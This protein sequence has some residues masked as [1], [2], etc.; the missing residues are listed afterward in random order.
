MATIEAVMAATAVGDVA[1]S[2]RVGKQLRDT[3]VLTALDLAQIGPSLV[4]E[5]WSVVL[6]RTVRELRGESCR[7]LRTRRPKQ[8]IAHTRALANRSVI[9][10]GSL[11]S[12]AF[13]RLVGQGRSASKEV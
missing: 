3:G 13:S 4:R 5:R 7:R 11:K 10:I 9:W 8:P 2:A 1:V 6:E 12:S